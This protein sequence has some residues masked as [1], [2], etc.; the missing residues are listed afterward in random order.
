MRWM[1]LCSHTIGWFLEMLKLSMASNLTLKKP[2]QSSEICGAQL[3]LDATA[4]IEL[5][6]EH[7]PAGVISSNSCKMLFGLTGSAFVAFNE[8]PQVEVL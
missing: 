8:G 3:M 6:D 2:K 5:E 7:D 1:R 4:L